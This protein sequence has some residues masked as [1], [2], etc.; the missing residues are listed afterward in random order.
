MNDF[1][2]PPAKEEENSDAKDLYEMGKRLCEMA[3]AMGYSGEAEEEPEAPA[4]PSPRMKSK[5]D[6]AMSFFGE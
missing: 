6:S 4:K 5:V 3:E 2:T 1:V